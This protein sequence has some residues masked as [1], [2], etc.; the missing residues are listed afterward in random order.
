MGAAGRL[1]VL[2]VDDLPAT[3]QGLRARGVACLATALY[4]SRPLGEAGQEFPQGRCV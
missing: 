4:N 3:L 1:P 2:H